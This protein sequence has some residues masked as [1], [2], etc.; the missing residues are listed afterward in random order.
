MEAI[1]A[2]SSVVFTMQVVGEPAAGIQGVW[3][4]YTGATPGVW[5]SLD[6]Q[7]NATDSTLWTGTLPGVAPGQVEFIVQAVNGVGLVSLD[8][9]QGSYY[10]PGQIPAALQTPGSLTPT[11]LV[12]SAPATGSYGSAVPLS[13]TL[14]QGSTPLAG[15]TVRFTLGGSEVTAVTNAAGVASVS[16]PTLATPRTYDVTA[17]FDGTTLLAAS[18]VTNSFT[19]TKLATT[20]SLSTSPQPPTVGGD[21]GV[22]ATLRT[23]AGVGIVDH[24]VIFR[25]TPATGPAVTVSRVTG[26]GGQARLGAVTLPGGQPLGAGTY[27][28]RAF[29]GP[30]AALGFVVPADA[31]YEPSSATLTG[32]L[33]LGRKVLFASTRTGNGDVYVVDPAGGPPTQLTSGSAIDAEPEWSPAGDKI[34]FS[35]TRSGNVEIFVMNW[36]GTNVTR[37]T[38]NSAIDTSPAWSPDGQKIAFASNRGNNWDIYVMNANGSGVQQRLTTHSQ[39]DLLPTWSPNS[40]QLAFMSTRSGNGDIYTMQAN[41]SS[42]TKRTTSSAIDTEPAWS[43]T[44]IAFSTNRHGSSNFEI[45]RMAQG[46]GSETRLTT[47]AG[48]DITPAWSTDGT[49][50]AFA[51]N[52]APAG[53]F[54]FDLYTMNA[55]GSSQ[56]P[57]V[58]H[59]AVDVF[60]DW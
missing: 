28:V 9:N 39:E 10:R 56:T 59:G 22:T 14:T 35:S 15:Q 26:A 52:R 38:T 57:L 48:H 25:V 58:T 31:L 60:P 24:S 33:T 37:L 13:A 6:L 34:V 3:I 49:R 45:Y 44:T 47:Q 40:G 42:Q 53:G 7:Q 1:D 4:T 11:T 19:V 2:V 17:A 43:G 16:M 50:L 36:D 27:A 51:S 55:N 8:D 46:G 5:Q 20:L 18:S 30:N 12:L 21:T 32:S 23:S 29:F 54:N 41:G